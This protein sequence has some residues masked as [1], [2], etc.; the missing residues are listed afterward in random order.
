MRKL[1]VKLVFAYMLPFI[2]E[3]NQGKIFDEL[4]PEDI[5]MRPI[6]GYI[7]FKGLKVKQTQSALIVPDK[8]QK[9]LS[10]DKFKERFFTHPTLAVVMSSGDRF[11]DEPKPYPPFTLAYMDTEADM[12]PIL[13]NVNGKKE[14]L[15]LVSSRRI[16]GVHDVP[17]SKL[18]SVKVL[19]RYFKFFILKKQ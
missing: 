14:I 18:M 15:D 5:E 8:A 1:K 7:Y 19:K 4:R 2:E 17:W 3:A 13:H 6:H 9:S 12:T 16:L 10:P 11:K